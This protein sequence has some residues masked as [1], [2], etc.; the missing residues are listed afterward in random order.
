MS[1]GWIRR[2]QADVSEIDTDGA[3]PNVLLVRGEATV[4]DVDGVAPEY[5]SSARRYLGED[6]ASGLLSMIDD[7]STRM[8]RIA[9]RPAWVGVLDF[10]SR[11]PGPI[12][13]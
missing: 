9:V 8:A 7:P 13:G 10:E 5:A 4:E 11:L 1:A 2:P 12:R 3:P 6:A